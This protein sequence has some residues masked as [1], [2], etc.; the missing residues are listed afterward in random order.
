MAPP[1]IPRKVYIQQCQ[2]VHGCKYY[3]SKLPKVFRMR[4]MLPIIC[5]EH[6]VFEQMA[7]AHKNGQGCRKCNSEARK[8]TTETFIQKAREVHGDT[9][10]YS[11]TRYTYSTVKVI[12]TCR[13]HGDFRQTPANH[14]QGQTCPKCADEL[15]GQKSAVPYEEFLERVRAV[16]GDTYK[17]NPKSYKGIM[18]PVQV[19][20]REHGVWWPLA[21]NLAKGK[22]CPDCSREKFLGELREK[23][24][25]RQA[26][27]ARKFIPLAKRVH[28]GFYDYSEVEYF[29]EDT[30]V[31][32]VCP[33]HGPF[34]QRPWCHIKKNPQGCKR[35]SDEKQSGNIE[36]F[37]QKAHKVHNNKYDYSKFIYVN[38]NTKGIIICPIHGEFKQAPSNHIDNGHNCPKCSNRASKPQEKIANFLRELGIE[39]VENTKRVL[40]PDK[41]DGRK[42][43]ELDFWVPSKRVAIEVNG[44]YWHSDAYGKSDKYHLQKTLLAKKRGIRLFQFWDEE[45][46]H[47]RKWGAIQN[48]IREILAEPSPVK[49]SL[50][51]ITPNKRDALR[52]LKAHSI[53]SITSWDVCFGV[54]N[55]D[56]QIV[57]LL[58]GKKVEGTLK[59]RVCGR[60]DKNIGK[61]LRD[62]VGKFE[63]IKSLQGKVDLRFSYG[64]ELKCLGLE[65]YCRQGPSHFELELG[66]EENP[67]VWDCGSLIF[68]KEIQK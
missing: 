29:T 24:L 1:P 28:K 9:Y 52:F 35:C 19:K 4:D 18:S 63:S 49:G 23:T 12:I 36:E 32:I 16:H 30:P 58:V 67:K 34:W 56:K 43:W 5:P 53:P 68:R 46:L 40:N 38:R 39:F 54:Q 8:Y 59:V 65:F 60:V 41:S 57:A 48:M 20:C 66:Y 6:G 21:D 61:L 37:K 13:E 25:Q 31:K 27:L 47:R 17:I 51:V 22:L 2:K 62:E 33:K 26:S 42:G 44:V 11:K 10:D 64:D 14:L 15:R 50:S 45:I 7:M 3:Y 55:E